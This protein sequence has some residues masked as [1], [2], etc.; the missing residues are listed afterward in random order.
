MTVFVVLEI[1]DDE[2]GCRG[3]RDIFSD[4]IAAQKYVESL[5]N[6]SIEFWDGSKQDKYIIQPYPVHGAGS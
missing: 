6:C 3:I 1:C 4:P 2:Y 5:G